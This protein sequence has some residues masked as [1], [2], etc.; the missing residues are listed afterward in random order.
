[1]SI[2]RAPGGHSAMISRGTSDPANRHTGQRATRF[3]PRTVIRSGA[4]GPAPMK[5]T[6]MARKSFNEVSVSDGSGGVRS[7]DTMRVT[8]R[9]ARSPAA[10]SAVGFAD[11]ADAALPEHAF[12][13]CGDRAHPP[14]RMRLGGDGLDR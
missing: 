4:P 9:R 5:C 7:A 13:A 12:R 11:A 8:T 10:A 2:T 3:W 6:V 14:A 1:M